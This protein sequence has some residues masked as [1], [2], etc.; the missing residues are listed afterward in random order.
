[1]VSLFT[2]NRLMKVGKNLHKS[3]YDKG[4][5]DALDI[6]LENF[7]KILREFEYTDYQKF[8]FEMGKYYAKP[9]EEK[10]IFNKYKKIFQKHFRKEKLNRIV[11]D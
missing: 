3:I 8:Y 9:D 4:I 11:N 7:Y 10:E 1:M 5:A 2:I 6:S